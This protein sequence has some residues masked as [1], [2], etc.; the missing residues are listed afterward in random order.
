MIPPIV[1]VA[2]LIWRRLNAEFG[3]TVAEAPDG[4]RVDGG[5]LGTRHETIPLPRVQAIRWDEPLLWRPFGWCRLEID[6]AQQRAARRDDNSS[7]PDRAL[8]PVGTRDQARAVLARVLPAPL[9]GDGSPHVALQARPPRRA[10]LKL[11]FSYPNLGLYSDDALIV[12]GHGIV[13]R[14]LVVVPL[15]KVQSLRFVQGPYARLLRLG[16]VHVDLVGRQWF[17]AAHARDIDEAERLWPSL[18]ERARRA[19]Q[20]AGS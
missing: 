9:P 13:R 10:R 5:L 17:A 1:A 15:A 6:V 3:L 4:L 8:L 18:A 11:P 20:A 19:R 12:C 2:A 14:R 7:F 16:T